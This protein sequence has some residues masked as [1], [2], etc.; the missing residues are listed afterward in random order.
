MDIRPLR[1]SRDFRL[2]FVGG[3]VS[4]V[5]SMVTYV[6]LPFQ[7]AELTGSYVAVGVLGLVELVPLVVFGLYGGA[8]AD[9]VDRRKLVLVTELGVTMVTSVLLVNALASRPS[10][11]VIYAASFAYAVL[12]SLQRPSLDAL[13]PRIVTP[14]HLAAAS[15]LNSLRMNIGTI[16]GPALGGV[17]IA[18]GGVQAAYAVDTISYAAS[19]AALLMMRATPPPLGADRPSMSGIWQGMQY[20]WVRKDLLGT[21]AI[22]LVAMLFVF[23]Y[24]LFP[25]I[26]LAYDSP[27]VLGLL[28][29][30]PYAGA[31]VAT[32][33]SGWTGH[34]HRHG[35]FIVAGALVWSG[36][37]IV[38]GV[39]PNLAWVLVFLAVAGAG[40][41][42]SGLFRALMWN[43]TI[44]DHLRGRLAGIELLSYSI[45]PQLGQVRSTLMA[46]VTS[47]R[48]S[49]WG[50]GLLGVV[51]VALVPFWLPAVWAFDDRTD[52]NAIEQRRIRTSRS[53]DDVDSV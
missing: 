30:A 35:R 16:A 31:L 28:Y 10:L 3:S 34:V 33:T 26:A 19:L 25:F 14:D 9:A 53:D 52:A 38:V 47:L 41:M 7:V 17:I 43:L 1:H 18:V 42:I 32:L 36:A 45:G 44:P 24:A 8:L 46:Q 20:A 2:L 21:Y 6:A 37:I 51:G 22:D 4:F 48:V 12:D 13:V 15:A 23:P 50:G 11:W 49:L 40:D 29:S 5:G 27:A 39:A